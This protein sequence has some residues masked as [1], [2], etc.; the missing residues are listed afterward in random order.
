MKRFFQLFFIYLLGVLFLVTLA[1][2]VRAIDSSSIS[3]TSVASN[4]TINISNYE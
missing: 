1:L 2:R 4:Y 3:N